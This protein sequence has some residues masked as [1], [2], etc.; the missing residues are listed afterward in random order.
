MAFKKMQADWIGNTLSGIFSFDMK[1][2]R[3]DRVYHKTNEMIN[4]VKMQRLLNWL[5]YVVISKIYK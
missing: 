3:W 4:T 2:K 1:G 5:F